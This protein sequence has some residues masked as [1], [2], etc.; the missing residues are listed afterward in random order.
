MNNPVKADSKKEMVK[1]RIKMKTEMT[2]MKSNKKT[3]QNL[4]DNHDK[5]NNIETIVNTDIDKQN[6][7]FKKLLEA[8]RRKTQ[9][10][11]SD[12]T[13]QIDVIVINYLFRKIKE[14]KMILKEGINH[15]I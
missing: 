7:N 5:T 3:V 9:L 14:M 13:E 15:L 6:E 10:S 1:K 4:I 12:V 2:E 8:K 11:T